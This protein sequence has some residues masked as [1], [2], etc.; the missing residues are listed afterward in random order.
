MNQCFSG[1]AISVVASLASLGK[2]GVINSC[3]IG[4]TFCVVTHIAICINRNV[5]NRGAKRNTVVMA[6]LA[7][8]WGAGKFGIYMT[9]LATQ[10]LMLAA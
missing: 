3:H 6:K 5:S 9:L 1:G 8:V 7:L 4:K 10:K 2:L